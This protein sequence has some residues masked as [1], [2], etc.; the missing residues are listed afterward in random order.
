MKKLVLIL[1]IFSCGLF[2]EN[3][4]TISFAEFDSK[5]K[6]IKFDNFTFLE[7]EESES[8]YQAA[9][10]DMKTKKSLFINVYNFSDFTDPLSPT[11]KVENLKEYEY[12]SNKTKYF[13][14]NNNSLL[15]I[16][17]MNINSSI[18]I[19]ISSIVEKEKL[20]KF[21]DLTDLLNFNQQS[22]AFPAE[23]PSELHIDAQI[24]SIEKMD[25]S[26][27]GYKYEYHITFVKSE[28]LIKSINKIL[29]QT[30]SGIDLINFK[31]VTLICGMT[32][33]MEELEKMRDGDI[34]NFIY[35]IK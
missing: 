6:N 27:D 16:L 21:L 31:N 13:T 28:R 29:K 8:Y 23:I 7:S 9:F 3:V 5:V 4:R 19:I 22:S 17:A 10:V 1:L 34:V 24:K 15:R 32:D 20:E 2:A 26:T 25:A 35:Y 12:K 11:G 30:S 14:F 18:E 33:S